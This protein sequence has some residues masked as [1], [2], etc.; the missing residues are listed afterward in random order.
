LEEPSSSVEAKKSTEHSGKTSTLWSD[1]GINKKKIPHSR[2]QKGSVL[3]REVEKRGTGLIRWAGLKQNVP[4]GGEK[5][6]PN[7]HRIGAD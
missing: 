6:E 3:R 2:E 1:M 4:L 7:P 5:G